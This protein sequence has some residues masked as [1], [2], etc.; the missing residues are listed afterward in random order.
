MRQFIILTTTLFLTACQ[1]SAPKADAY[2]NFEADERIIS[3]EASGRI[4]A[5]D[6]EEGQSLRA[7]TAIGAIDSV[8][9]VLRREQLQ[10]TIR[11]V[12]AKSP[13]ISAQLAVFDKQMATVR[14]QL[15]TLDREKRRLENL[16]KSDAATPKQLDDLN[17]QVEAAQR[18]MDVLHEQQTATNAALTTQKGGLLA[19]IAPLQKQ[20]EQL[21][22]QIAKC[23]ITAPTDGTV[24][25]KYAEAGEV[26]TFGKPLFKIADLSTVTLRVF[27]AGDQLASVQ[28]GQSVKVAID[29][30]EGK[31][32]DFTGR[33][34]WISPKAEFTPK[35]VQTKEER[36]NLVYAVKISLPNPDGVLKIGMPGEMRFI[37]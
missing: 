11:A 7:E 15:A 26:T 1:P 32:R 36:V 13:A 18:Q 20:I 24:L 27:V 29:T 25:V 28:V 33:V 4:L 21:D 10:A 3:A 37:K 19:E 30:E 17:A 6:I 35:I 9:L 12:A 23:R 22:D 8:Q 2:G 5:F 16:V 31:Q 34:Q 14:Q